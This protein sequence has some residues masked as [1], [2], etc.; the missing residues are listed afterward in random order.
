[1]ETDIKL[2]KLAGCAGCGAKVGAGT[3]VKLLD[4][5]K[6]HTDPNLI[7]GY[8]KS[9]DASVYVINDDTAVVQTT[10]FFPPIV[11]DPYLYGQIAATN[12]ISDVYAMGAEPKLALNIMCITENMDKAV[13]QEILRGGYDKAYEAGVIITGGHTIHGAEPIYGLA[14][15]GF[16]NP[17]KVLTNSGAKPGDVMILTKPLGVGIITTAAKAELIDKKVLDKIYLQMATLNKSARD[18]M[19]NYSVHSCTD[20]TGFSLL[21]HSYEMAQGSGCTINIFANKIPYHKEAYEFAEMGFI[22]AGAYRNREY[23][24]AGVK[25]VGNIERPMMDICFD[26]Q[27]SGGLLISIDNKDAH[28]AL[29]EMKSAG[30][31]AE[32]IGEVS[33]KKDYPIYLYEE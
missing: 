20:V 19:I 33:E 29:I 21:G 10:D 24:E 22:P 4:G 17:K 8:D 15:S 27:T 18:I 13:V 30:V 9:D 28:N 12:A 32:I 16:V 31:Q 25:V 23:A 14:V 7:V 3:L 26:P 2:T 5:F 1:M 11:D 6:T